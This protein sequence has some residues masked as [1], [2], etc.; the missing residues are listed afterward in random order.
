MRLPLLIPDAAPR[1]VDAWIAE[2]ARQ[3]AAFLQANGPRVLGA[4]SW[5]EVCVLAPRNAW[6][7]TVQKAFEAAGLKVA[8]QTRK[9]RHGD[10]PVY[11]WMAGLV[12]VVCDPDN[13]FEWFG[14]LR[15]IFVISDAL[16]A[17][18]VRERGAFRWDSPEEHAPEIAAAL[19][20]LRPWILRADDEGQP[21]GV[22]ARG[23]AEV[24]GL[25][26][27]ARALDPSGGLAD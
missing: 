5:G 17:D 27:K 24:C 25:E 7:V 8:L 2:E 6:L 13:T 18:D 1:G 16:L 22:M 9:S 15:D 26:A 10:N 23:L 12:A 3:V 21:L 11:G 14:V 20:K 19:E 4:Q